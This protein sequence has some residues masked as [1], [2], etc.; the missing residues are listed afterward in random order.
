MKHFVNGREIEFVKIPFTILKEDWQ[1]Y[2]AGD[3]LIKF[4]CCVHEFFLS[5]EPPAEGEEPMIHVQSKA[6]LA[7][8]KRETL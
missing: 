5:V 4:K 8:S 7:V 1:E 6:V 3:Y 2:V